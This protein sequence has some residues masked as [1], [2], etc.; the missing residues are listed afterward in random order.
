MADSLQPHGLQHTRLPCLSP[1]PRACSNS[2]P[3]SSWCHPTIL[4]SVIPFSSCLQSL[5]ASGSFLMSH[6]FTSGDQSIGASASS[7]LL[8][9]NIQD[10]SPLWLTGLISLQPMG[11]SRVF[12]NTTTLIHQKAWILW[13]SA[14]FMVQISHLYMT[15]GKT[16]VLTIQILP[17]NW[18]LCFLIR[19]LGLS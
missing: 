7:S 11:L 16:I 3:S 5:P 14:F 18:C 10:W 4:S 15:I 8:P 17:A 19:S 13:C 2:C 1:I 12:S 6:F 9:V